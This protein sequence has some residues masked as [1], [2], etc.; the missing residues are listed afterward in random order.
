MI[1]VFILPKD[2]IKQEEYR[3][4]MRILALAGG[5]GKWFKGRPSPRR[6]KDAISPPPSRKGIIMSESQK[7]KIRIAV[8]KRIEKFGT[9]K[10]G[11]NETVIL[12][13]IE[14]KDNVKIQRQYTIYKLG[15]FVDGYCKETNTVYEVDEYN[16]KYQ[17]EKDAKRQ[18]EIEEYLHCKFIRIDEIDWI[19]KNGIEV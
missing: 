1:G 2:P 18:K 6:G 5:Y 19:K 8:Q 17:K 11:K 12:N 9:L 15:Y 16:H 7:G 4:K 3:Q 10:I 13:R 14:L